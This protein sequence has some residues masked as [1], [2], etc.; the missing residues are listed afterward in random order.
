MGDLPAVVNNEAR[1][2]FEIKLG[3][4]TAF[5]DY[6]LTRAGL[7]LPHVEVPPALEDRGVGG[8]LAEAAMR[9]AREHGLK[10]M[11]TCPFMAD[12]VRR[13]PETHDLVHRLWRE[14]LGIE[15]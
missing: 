13:R 14:R 3:G 12:Y 10:V 5:A 1:S 11:P 6:R 8:R 9:Y 4:E 2:R 15:G 7:V